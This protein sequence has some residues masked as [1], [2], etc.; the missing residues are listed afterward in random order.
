MKGHY[1]VCIDP[2]TGERK[3]VHRWVM[4]QVS[5]RKLRTGE[6]VHHIDGDTWNNKPHN[7]LL[8]ESQAIHMRLEHYLRRKSRGVECLF[9][10]ETWLAMYATVTRYDE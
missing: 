10:L 1:L 7:L 4:Q 9:D 5:G 8:L 2:K 3:H 6:V